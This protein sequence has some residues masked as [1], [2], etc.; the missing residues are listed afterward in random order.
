MA[1]SSTD[2]A[3]QRPSGTI[4]RDDIAPGW[5]WR[6][7]VWI[8]ALTGVAVGVVLLLALDGIADVAPNGA[9]VIEQDMDDLAGW[10]PATSRDAIDWDWG[11]GQLTVI[12]AETRAV[13]L[14][15]NILS[16]SG[17][18]LI[19]LIQTRGPQEAGYGLWWGDAADGAFIV[20]AL[21][22]DG[23]VTIQRFDGE[24]STP[25]REWQFFPHVRPLSQ[26]NQIQVDLLGDTAVVW[27][28]DEFVSELDRI[29]I[30]PFHT[31]V[32]AETFAAGGLT[33]R[34][35]RFAV[36]EDTYP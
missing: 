30:Q 14:S 25:L 27:I 24:A 7:S 3:R 18:L 16:T 34:I 26:V 28:N 21:N 32:Y 12:E 9:P 13:L 29:G 2:K 15:P 10:T 36:W 22:T 4:I 31:G 17:T 35:E 19:R 33:V 5:V 23:Y 8:T 11:T 20:V 6:A 1:D